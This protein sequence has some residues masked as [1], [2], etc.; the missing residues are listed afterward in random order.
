[1]GGIYPEEHKFG[2][3]I[4]GWAS[5]AYMIK[6]SKLRASA[7]ASSND[8]LQISLPRTWNPKIVFS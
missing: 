5:S 6:P 3:H 7:C 2:K 1:M 8:S 4:L